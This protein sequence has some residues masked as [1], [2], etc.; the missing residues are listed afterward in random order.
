MSDQP[1]EGPWRADAAG[2]I[3]AEN[4]RPGQ[5]TVA[6]LKRGAPA[7]LLAAAPDL[8]QALQDGVEC[9]TRNLGQLSTGALEVGALRAKDEAERAIVRAK[10]GLADFG[11]HTAKWEVPVDLPAPERRANAR[12]L[13][14]APDLREACRSVYG[15]LATRADCV[16]AIGRL[17]AVISRTND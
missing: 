16:D 12:L 13:G 7:E 8:L 4:G 2:I 15:I 1:T 17:H 10:V 5:T 6:T 3:Y 11:G 9:L 14:A